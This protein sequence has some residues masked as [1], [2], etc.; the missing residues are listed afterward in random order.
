ML[1]ATCDRC[2]T[3]NLPKA[4]VVSV[5]AGKLN[6]LGA[7]DPKANTEAVTV[8]PLPELPHGTH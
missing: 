6:Y 1:T 2:K 5:S 8:E 3:Q 7:N 4:S